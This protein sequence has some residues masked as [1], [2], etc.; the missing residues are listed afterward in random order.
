MYGSPAVV[1]RFEKLIVA[2]VSELTPDGGQ[3][4]RGNLNLIAGRFAPVRNALLV[5]PADLF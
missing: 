4:N 2:H 3:G 5:P 1:P